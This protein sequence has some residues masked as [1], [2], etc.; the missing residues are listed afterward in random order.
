VFSFLGKRW[1]FRWVKSG[2]LRN[3][4][5]EC[6]APTTKRK[7]IR[8]VGNQPELD[9]LDTLIHE[10]LHACDWHKDEEWIGQAASDLARFIY[11]NGWRRHRE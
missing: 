6:D 3:K 7:E 9:E 5:G 8:I 10:G 4:Y 2:E 1:R 11:A